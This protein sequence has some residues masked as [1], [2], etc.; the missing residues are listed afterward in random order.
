VQEDNISI[1]FSGQEKSMLFRSTSVL[2]LLFSLITLLGVPLPVESQTPSNKPANTPTVSS[3]AWSIIDGFRSATFGMGKEQILRSI[4][5]DFKIPKK[6]VVRKI[7]SK[8][9]T[10]SFSILAPDLLHVGGVAKIVYILGYK[11]KKLMQVNIYW[12][13]EVADNLGGKEILSAAKLLRLHLDKKRYQE[14]GHIVNAKRNGNTKV[15]FL[16]SDEKK[17]GILIRLL[18]KK[19][20]NTVDNKETVRLVVSYMLD[21]AKPDIFKKP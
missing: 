3:K 5:K 8:Q 11:S 21:P 9:K 14:K 12:G 20:K 16:G 2:I 15:I 10:V 17:R 13:P 18:Y 7:N 4:I 6:N 1:Y 19:S